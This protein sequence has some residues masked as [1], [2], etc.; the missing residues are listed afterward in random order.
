[1]K[2]PNLKLSQFRNGGQ[3]KSCPRCSERAGK[4]V[5]FPLGTF[6]YRAMA[7]GS[8]QIQTWCKD[9]RHVE[10]RPKRKQAWF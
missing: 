2:R 4:L 3:E 10:A 5:F 7:D 6:G 1:M 9:C 8:T